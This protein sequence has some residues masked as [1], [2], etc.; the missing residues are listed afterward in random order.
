MPMNKC[1][2]AKQ[3]SG[4]REKGNCQP[5][6]PKYSLLNYII[7]IFKSQFG[8]AK[9]PKPNKS[10]HFSQILTFHLLNYL[11]QRRKDF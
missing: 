3:F 5:L 1:N 9:I 11:L 6:Q 10:K 7:H 2:Q 8:S 4:V